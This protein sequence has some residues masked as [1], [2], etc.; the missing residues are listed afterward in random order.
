MNDTS[1]GCSAE[2]AMSGR[3]ILVVDGNSRD[4]QNLSNWL[5]AEGHDVLL[6]A[7]GAQAVNTV[8]G[9]QL[10][11]VILNTSFPPDVANGGGVFD[12]GLHVIDWLKRIKE[13]ETLHF[14]LITDEDAAKLQGKAKASGAKGLC[15]KPINPET[16]LG[17]VQRILGGVPGTA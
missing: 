2:F 3:R 15:Q 11:L 4:R 6:A 7:D 10:D 1:S 12:D 17:V 14:L 5:S 8:R 16:L 13:A 9:Q